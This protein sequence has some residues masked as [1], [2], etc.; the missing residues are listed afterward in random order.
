MGIKI[1]TPQQEK[2]CQA[3]A[4]TSHSITAVKEAYECK[5]MKPSSIVKKAQ[6]LLENVL[7]T[8]RIKELTE[9]KKAVAD[10]KFNVT[11]HS[12][13]EH[14]YMISR[15]NIADYIKIIDVEIKTI[16]KVGKKETVTIK[17]VQESRYKTIEELT[18]DQQACVKSF[19]N[20]PRGIKIVLH[21]K[22]WV[23]KEINKHIGF[24]NEDEDQK[25]KIY[26][27]PEER[28]GR[29][30]EMGAQLLQKLPIEMIEA[31]LKRRKSK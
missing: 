13:L 27:S 5:T 31:E 19:E 22:D 4:K 10:V 11:A 12:I 28:H 2:F 18:P 20:T 25:K 24:Y 26:D 14:L 16:T 8:S 15:A 1:L 21:G 9:A 29:I 6:R 17:T 30:M 3:Y 7:I 23:T